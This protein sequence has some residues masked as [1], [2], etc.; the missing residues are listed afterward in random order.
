MFCARVENHKN[1]QGYIKDYARGYKKGF[2]KR[3][4]YNEKKFRQAKN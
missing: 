1:V 4:R 3:Y 2:I